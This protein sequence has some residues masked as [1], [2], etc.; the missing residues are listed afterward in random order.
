MMED[1]SRGLSLPLLRFHLTPDAGPLH[2]TTDVRV[3]GTLDY[4]D[5]AQKL[6]T[7]CERRMS[8]F[9]EFGAPNRSA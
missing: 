6:K 5:S 4:T 3:T 8:V 2:S 7:V 9:P 1:A